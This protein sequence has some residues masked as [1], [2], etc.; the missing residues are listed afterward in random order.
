MLSKSTKLLRL[1]H[2]Q[3]LG[4]VARVI[5]RSLAL[6]VAA[7]LL[8]APLVASQPASGRAQDPRGA[9]GIGDPYFPL[10]GNGG[11][12][13]KSYDV[14]DRY[15]FDER[16]LSGWTRIMLRPTADLSGFNLDFLLPVKSVRI[17]GDAV[18]FDH[19]SHEL[20]INAPV[21]EGDLVNL[22]V[23]YA[24][25]PGHYSYAGESN[26]LADR[27]EVSANGNRVART[28]HGGLATT[29][30]LPDEPMVPYLAFFAAGEFAVAKGTSH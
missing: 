26:W 11:I 21:A 8:A 24:G 17:D 2:D 20:E 19:H 16:R 6:A 25:F 12:D 1:Y 3:F 13:V 7:G 15:R 23:K 5:R 14:H 27:K 18:D 30:W 29:T 9:S 10:D 28:V 22:V 4:Y